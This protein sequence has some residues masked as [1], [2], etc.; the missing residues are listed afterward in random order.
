M[1]MVCGV[2]GMELCGRGMVME[3]CGDDIVMMLCGV[4]NVCGEDMVM[5]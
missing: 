4:K 5:H 1:V 3:L 2:D